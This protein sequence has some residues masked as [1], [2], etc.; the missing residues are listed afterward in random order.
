VVEKG[1]EGKRENPSSEG[2]ESISMERFQVATGGGSFHYV[3]RD[4]KGKKRE[5]KAG[6]C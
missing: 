1:R 4:L 5:R 6:Q 2:V 3:F